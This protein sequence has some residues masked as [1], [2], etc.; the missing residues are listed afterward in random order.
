MQ[1]KENEQKFAADAKKDEEEVLRLKEA[2]KKDEQLAAQA[3]TPQEK[4]KILA[5]EKV[6]SSPSLPSFV[7]FYQQNA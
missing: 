4:A 7:L 5:E 6:S 3:K 2:I 1:I